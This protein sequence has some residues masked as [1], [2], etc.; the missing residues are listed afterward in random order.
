M[1]SLKDKMKPT[2]KTA[3]EKAPSVSESFR[4]PEANEQEMKP[5][6][7][8]IPKELHTQI[9]LYAAANDIKQ[10]VLVAQ[11]LQEFLEKRA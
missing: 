7:V 1:S 2:G 4:N 6:N 5:L 9:K 8:R 10:Q 3:N 11:A